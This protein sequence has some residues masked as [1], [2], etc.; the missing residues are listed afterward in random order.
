L[1][2]E[3]DALVLRRRDARDRDVTLAWTIVNIAAATWSKGRIP[4]LQPLLSAAQ[5]GRPQ[6]I[7]E[8]RAVLQQLAQRLGTPLQT[9]GSRGRRPAPGQRHPTARVRQPA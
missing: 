5:P 3:I 1:F 4:D 2:D 9:K 8:Q 6:T 7:E